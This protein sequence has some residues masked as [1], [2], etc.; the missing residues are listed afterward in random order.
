MIFSVIYNYDLYYASIIICNLYNIILYS[1]S[2]FKIEKIKSII[3]NSNILE[4]LDINSDF[5][6]IRAKKFFYNTRYIRL[7]QIKLYLSYFTKISSF[8]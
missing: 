2:K 1:L 8:L 7:R 3:Y 6:Y 5:W 4:V